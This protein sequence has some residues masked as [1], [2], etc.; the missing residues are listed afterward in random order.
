MNNNLVVVASNENDDVVTVEETI[1]AIKL[2]GF[3]NVFV[4]WYDN[5]YDFSQLQ[6]VQLC[7]KL[8]LNIEFAHL[9]YQNMSYIW[10]PDK[11]YDSFVTRY[12]KDLDDLKQYGINH[13]IMHI[14]G[15]KQLFP[16]NDIGLNRFKRIVEC[17]KELNIKI[18]D[19]NEW[20]ELIKD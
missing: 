15:R 2:A 14:N 7:K 20:L 19:E 17:A 12:I 18:L 4:Q 3:E 11:E 13:A 10:S 1:N 9:G 16:L 8:G 6:Q 5:E